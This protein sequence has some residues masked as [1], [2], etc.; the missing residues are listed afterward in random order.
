MSGERLA[1][2]QRLELIRRVADWCYDNTESWA[3]GRIGLGLAYLF[4]SIAA[5][6]GQPF[7]TTIGSKDEYAELVKLLK[8]NPNRLW[9]K[10]KAIGA[11][12]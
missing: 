1:A 3:P 8:S 11:I 9:D 10:L 4:W 12:V 2:E 6:D 7:D 5:D